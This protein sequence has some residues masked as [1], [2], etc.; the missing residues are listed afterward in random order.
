ML[1]YI[2]SQDCFLTA[3]LINSEG[4]YATRDEVRRR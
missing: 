1:E 3:I 2:Q 4:L